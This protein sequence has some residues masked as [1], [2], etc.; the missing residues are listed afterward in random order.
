MHGLEVVA[1]AAVVELE[2]A[3]IAVVAA[4]FLVLVY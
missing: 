2:A 3:G 4:A 1:E